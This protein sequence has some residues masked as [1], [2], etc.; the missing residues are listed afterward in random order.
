M[1]ENA[2][3]SI[4]GSQLSSDSEEESFELVTDG[5][6]TPGKD[7]T[8]ISYM[9]SD[10]TGCAGTRTS[11]LV[12]DDQVVLTRGDGSSG[13]MV[14]SEARKH[15]FIYNTPFGALIMGLETQSIV[16]D[17]NDDGGD[18]EI[19]YI[20]DV[21]NLVASRNKFK[22]NIRKGGVANCQT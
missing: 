21:D 18:L 9:E 7:I 15:H 13:D 5:R 22:I 2:R 19:R 11:F 4:I 12:G 10:M 6:Y 16:K 1:V 17:M 14:F 3:I 20:L 8:E